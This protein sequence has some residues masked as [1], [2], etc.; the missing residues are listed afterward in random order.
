MKSMRGKDSRDVKTISMMDKKLTKEITPVKIILDTDNEIRATNF[1][2]TSKTG[3]SYI[4]PQL[5]FM[6]ATG[7]QKSVDISVSF[8]QIDQIMVAL[9]K[10]REEN[11]QYFNE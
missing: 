4:A 7:K 11:N 3:K 8:N 6:K 2:G 5:V 10:I 9:K 1:Y